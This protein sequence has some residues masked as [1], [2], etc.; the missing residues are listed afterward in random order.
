MGALAIAGVLSRHELQRLPP[1]AKVHLM[2]ALARTRGINWAVLA[3]FA[4]L[5][6]WRS[7]VG[8]MFLGVVAILVP[9][10]FV[11]RLNRLDLPRAASRGFVTAHLVAC[12]GV[13]ACAGIFIGRSIW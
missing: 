2:G 13:L 8:W 5:V 7:T 11:P 1:E 9:I 4:G 6:L 12:G 10:W 3:V